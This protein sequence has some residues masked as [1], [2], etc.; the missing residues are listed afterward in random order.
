MEASAQQLQIVQKL[1]SLANH[2]EWIESEALINS[3]LLEIA[4][5]PRKSIFPIE[6]DQ[7]LE[8]LDS[9][10]VKFGMRDYQELIL[11]NGCPN[12]LLLLLCE[13]R[14]FLNRPDNNTIHEISYLWQVCRYPNRASIIKKMIEK[15]ARI[16]EPDETGETSLHYAV[17]SRNFQA[18]KLLLYHGADANAKGEYDITPLHYATMDLYGFDVNIVHILLDFSADPNARLID[19]PPHNYSP[20]TYALKS[21]NP[22]EPDNGLL[23]VE[24]LVE[25]GGSLTDAEDEIIRDHIQY[26]GDEL[27]KA[28]TKGT[29]KRFRSHS[30][31]QS[32][33]SDMVYDKYITPRS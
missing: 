23:I 26:I 28:Y 22:F 9:G 33:L 2:A 4:S 3:V 31:I 21:I 19:R 17:R 13:D 1:K 7:Q 29:I 8:K 6:D 25:H 30:E 10:Q 20:M 14:N 5:D 24:L 27:I 18:V 12:S 15:G 16:D 32:I 11:S